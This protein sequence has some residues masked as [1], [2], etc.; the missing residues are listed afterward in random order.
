MVMQFAG[1]T[2]VVVYL[3][4]DFLWLKSVG[5]HLET[6][7]SL[8]SFLSRQQN[9][10]LFWFCTGIL[11]GLLKFSV[12]F[13]L[14]L[15]PICIFIFYFYFWVFPKV[16]QL[17]ASGLPISSLHPQTKANP[18]FTYILDTACHLGDFFSLRWPIFAHFN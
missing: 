13:L 2:S 4:D 11:G 5:Q 10:I 8:H 15:L 12:P 7:D 18:L 6:G 1:V 3:E 14:F 9:S 16:W 17:V